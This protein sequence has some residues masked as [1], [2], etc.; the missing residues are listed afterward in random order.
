MIEFESLQ[1]NIIKILFQS[2]TQHDKQS[3]ILIIFG[4]FSGAVLNYSVSR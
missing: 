1:R 2:A 3:Y 4:L